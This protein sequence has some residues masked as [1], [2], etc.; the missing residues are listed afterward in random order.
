MACDE[1]KAPH[2]TALC[3]GLNASERVV[4][5]FDASGRPRMYKHYSEC[6]KRVHANGAARASPIGYS[7]PG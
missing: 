2:M 1:R 4:S 3:A 7:Y 6:L 5:W